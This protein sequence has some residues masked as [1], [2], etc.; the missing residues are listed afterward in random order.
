MYLMISLCNELPSDLQNCRETGRKGV[1]DWET[2]RKRCW[3]NGNE[4][5][6]GWKKS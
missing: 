3:K 6:E 4:A 5:F 1:R 2:E